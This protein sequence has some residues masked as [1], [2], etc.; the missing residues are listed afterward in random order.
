M[1][2]VHSAGAQEGGR[3][4]GA[5]TDA[6]TGPG[7][8]G[9]ALSIDNMS[10]ALLPKTHGCPSALRASPE[11]PEMRKTSENFSTHGAACQEGP[12]GTPTLRVSAW[13]R[14]RVEK[15]LACGLPRRLN[16]CPFLHCPALPCGPPGSSHPWF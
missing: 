2:R 10:E 9:Q 11:V 3:E 8:Q 6:K 4:G 15:P 5:A 16:C 13:R 14:Q 12:S 1:R 7:R